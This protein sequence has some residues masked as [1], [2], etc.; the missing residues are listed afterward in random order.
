M[1]HGAALADETRISVG[2]GKVDLKTHV[3][4][5]STA[6][7][8]RG[9]W[10]RAEGDEGDF[11]YGLSFGR[12]SASGSGVLPPSPPEIPNPLDSNLKYPEIETVGAALGWHGL[13]LGGYGFGP[14]IAYERVAHSDGTLSFLRFTDPIPE[15]T[16]EQTV[17][18]V[19]MRTET[20]GFDFSVTAGSVIMGN[21]WENGLAISIAADVHVTEAVTL[22]GN[23][24]RAWGKQAVWS[25]QFEDD[26]TLID[27]IRKTEADAF[28]LGAR[29]SVADGI[30]LESWMTRARNGAYIDFGQDNWIT[31]LNIGFGTSF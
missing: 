7:N 1:T 5:N 11:L 19:L 25:G 27:V 24:T 30:F 3:G 31:T 20:D 21:A 28:G 18:G 12:H 29:V 6:M 8:G 10:L 15:E 13:S 22:M 14:F 4:S 9:Y 26:G 23:W 16:M 17:A 2:Y